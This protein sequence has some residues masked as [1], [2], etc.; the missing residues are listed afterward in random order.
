VFF[1]NWKIKHKLLLLVVVNMMFLVVIGT[2]GFSYL[3]KIAEASEEMYKD[4]LI[5]VKELM[6]MRGNYRS[7]ASSSLELLMATDEKRKRELENTI[8]DSL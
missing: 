2:V 1:K 7:V 5:P 3:N 8:T 4:R 6:V